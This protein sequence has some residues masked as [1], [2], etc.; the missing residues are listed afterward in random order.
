MC[1]NIAL[2]RS[3]IANPNTIRV[4]AK[5]AMTTEELSDSL[6]NLGKSAGAQARKA[7]EKSELQLIKEIYYVRKVDDFNYSKGRFRSHVETE[8]RE[9]WNHIQLNDF[10]ETH[11]SP[12]P[13]FKSATTVISSYKQDVSQ[14]QIRDWLTQFI[15]RL[16]QDPNN[17]PA[18]HELN[19]T[20][21]ALIN[22]LGG[23]ELDWQGLAAIDGFKME[24]ESVPLADG[25]ILR[26]PVESDLE[27]RVPG[28]MLLSM[29]YPT[30]RRNW[31]MPGAI[32]EL[33]VRGTSKG[34]VP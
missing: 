1:S 31:G 4:N 12:C 5:S 22:E 11:V 27:E 19:R 9:Q 17:L 33:N 30:F 15:F 13:E 32:L 21:V 26:K 16:I 2:P 18:D 6:W 28:Y 20:V 23:G 25:V 34:H 29:L 8:H 10:I 24:P 7:L 3:N 14:G